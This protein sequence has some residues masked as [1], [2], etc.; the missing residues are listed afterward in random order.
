MPKPAG[1][2]ACRQ[3][4]AIPATGGPED[5]ITVSGGSGAGVGV[6]GAIVALTLGA[7][8]AVVAAERA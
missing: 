6:A 2:L 3:D 7:V 8:V 4:G 5:E 1:R